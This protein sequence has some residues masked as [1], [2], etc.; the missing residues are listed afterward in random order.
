[1][2]EWDLKVLDAHYNKPTIGVEPT[3]FFE[4]NITFWCE[5]TAF[6]E[7][8]HQLVDVFCEPNGLKTGQARVQVF[9]FDWKR[10]RLVDLRY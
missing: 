2:E 8:I 6:F 4:P 10:R 7:L 9:T 1:M 5:P 3:V